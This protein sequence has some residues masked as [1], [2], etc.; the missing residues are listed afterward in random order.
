MRWINVP[1]ICSIEAI[2]SGSR[3]GFNWI[4]SCETKHYNISVLYLF[5]IF[6]IYEYLFKKCVFSMPHEIVEVAMDLE[7]YILD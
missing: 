5:K 7:K 6:N 1:N 2:C 3:T 4:W